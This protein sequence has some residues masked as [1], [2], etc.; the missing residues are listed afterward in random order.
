MNISLITTKFVTKAVIFG[1]SFSF[2]NS[3]NKTKT[4]LNLVT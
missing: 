4:L 1:Y 3:N 2:S